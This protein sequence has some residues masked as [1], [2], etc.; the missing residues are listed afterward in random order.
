MNAAT[1]HTGD[2]S[3]CAPVATIPMPDPEA[4]VGAIDDTTHTLYASDESQSGTVAVINTA[5]CN[6]ADTTGC[7][8]PPTMIGIGAF[9]AQPVLNPGTHTMYVSYGLNG[10][11]VAVVNAATCNA[12]DTTGCG[13]APAVVK[14]GLFTFALA[15]SAATDTVYAP[16]PGAGFSGDTVAVINGATCNGTDHSGCGHLAATAKAGLGPTGIA[17]DDQTHTVYVANNADGD[18]PGTVSVINGATCN[19]TVTT[20]CHHRSPVMPVGRS[21]L[22]VALDPATGAVYVTDFSSASVTVLYGSRCNAE[23]TAGCGTAGREQAVG[24]QP[25]GLA[26]D[27]VT[28]TVYVAQIFQ[29]GFLGVVQAARH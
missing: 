13:Q 20:G 14:V 25:L 26:V 9:P 19:G 18:A 8:Q 12:T 2:L 22:L 11:K 21:P 3:G 24:S 28:R 27:P 23:V 29:S 15:V 10:N 7:A 5:T 6:A 16:A 17:V 1:C 4:N